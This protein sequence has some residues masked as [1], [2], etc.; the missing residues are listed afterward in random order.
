MFDPDIVIKK[1]DKGN[2][3]LLMDKEFYRDKLVLQDHLYTSTY[4]PT[5]S[6]A[7]KETFSYL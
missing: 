3:L 7:D 1:A 5:H 6:S 2:V 4:C